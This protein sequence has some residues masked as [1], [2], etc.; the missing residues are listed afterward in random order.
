M[1]WVNKLSQEALKKASLIQ[2]DIVMGGYG[3]IKGDTL[4]HLAVAKKNQS[5]VLALIKKIDI[6]ALNDILFLVPENIDKRN[7]FLDTIN[8][9]LKHII[10]SDTLSSKNKIELLNKLQGCVASR[11][12]SRRNSILSFPFNLEL[13][14]LTKKINDRVRECVSVTATTP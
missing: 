3:T 14:D 13:Y 4:L 6:K 11:R 12:N 2:D 7:F 9:A 1:A 5:V 8:F 10:P